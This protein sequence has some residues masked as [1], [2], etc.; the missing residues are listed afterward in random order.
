MVSSV[1]IITPTIGSD[2]L[3][4]CVTSVQQQTY[5][6]VK[7]LVVIDGGHHISKVMP[8]I[9]EGNKTNC[10]VCVLPTNVGANGWYGHRIYAAFSYL[11]NE[12]YICFLDED[13]WV[14][15]IM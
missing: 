3:I 1:V 9:G 8:L 12:D 10:R 13:N 15:Q 4:D 2:H 7:H 14:V 11:V 6:N 5:D